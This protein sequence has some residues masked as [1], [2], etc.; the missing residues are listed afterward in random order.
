MALDST[1]KRDKGKVLDHI[2][3]KWESQSKCLRCG[4]ALD[5]LEVVH[6]TETVA[7]VWSCGN[8][9]DGVVSGLKLG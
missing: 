3:R 6:L 1:A 5:D 8:G 2:I 4:R 7:V 9:H